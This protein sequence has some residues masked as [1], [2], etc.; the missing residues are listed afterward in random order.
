MVSGAY[1]KAEFPKKQTKVLSAGLEGHIG[2][3]NVRTKPASDQS[4]ESVTVM[5]IPSAV[6]LICWEETLVK[7]ATQASPYPVTSSCTTLFMRS[8]EK[9]LSVG[10]DPIIHNAGRGRL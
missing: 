10:S 7:V 8:G 4:R 5:P 2:V 9:L 1:G 3:T 6:V